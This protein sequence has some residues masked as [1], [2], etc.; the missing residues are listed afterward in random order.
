MYT[1]P[2]CNL[3]CDLKS[4]ARNVFGQ[5]VRI[6]LKHTVNSLAIFLVYFCAKIQ[7]Y[8]VFLQK[9]HGSPHICL[10]CNLDSN[11]PR[12]FLTDP[13]DF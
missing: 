6:L 3:I 4:H 12:F 7:G 8:P 2:G 13:F 10:F 9:D 11:L 5:A 1:D